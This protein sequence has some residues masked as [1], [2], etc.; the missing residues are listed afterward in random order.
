MRQNVVDS[1][2]KSFK[3]SKIIVLLK[4]KLAVNFDGNASSG[5]QA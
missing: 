5:N 2:P 3:N 4:K 1:A